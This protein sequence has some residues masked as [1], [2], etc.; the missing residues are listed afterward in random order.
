[1]MLEG[2]EKMAHLYKTRRKIPSRRS[3]LFFKRHQNR[4]SSRIAALDRICLQT[5]PDPALMYSRDPDR[6]F[7][8]EQIAVYTAVFG[9][10]DDVPEPLI[11]PDN[12]D[13][14]LISETAPAG[15]DHEENTSG[16]AKRSRWNYMSAKDVVPEEYLSDPVLANRW[17]KMHPHLLFPNFTLS[18]YVDSNVLIVSD[19]TALT[20]TM[21]TF[22]AAM[23]LHKQRDCVYEEIRACILKKKDKEETL[24][25][26]E[27]LLRSHHIPEHAGLLEAPVIVRRHNDPRCKDL[28][29]AWWD[30]FRQGSRRDQIALI[31]ALFARQVRVSDVG[32]LGNNILSCDLLLLMPHKG[33]LS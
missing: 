22:P 16:G 10:Y 9:G 5:E 31:D 11:R 26:Q 33:V 6:Y 19:L 8:T 13:Y 2:L 32:T 23:F 27:A 21:Q 3:G 24:R 25:A 18:V 14:F 12:I 20:H 1:M 29:D 30:A 15:T 17:C 7:G 4:A 28:M